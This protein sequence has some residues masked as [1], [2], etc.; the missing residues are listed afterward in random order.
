MADPT[1]DNFASDIVDSTLAQ[2]RD[3]RDI[4]GSNDLSGEIEVNPQAFL[5][6]NRLI[7]GPIAFETSF[8]S[9]P[10]IVFGDMPVTDGTNAP[11][12]PF[13]VPDNYAPFLVKAYVSSWR[14]TNG[15]FDGFN[16]GLYAL[17]TPPSGVTKHIVWWQAKGKASVYRDQKTDESWAEP[18]DFND[19]DFLT[20][21]ADEDT[22][23]S[24]EG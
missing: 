17:T 21:S 20:E 18:Y 15:V 1:D 9:R 4:D 24:D 23:V 19:A 11:N 2:I 10:N 22:Y 5:A 8:A 6:G 16:L 12:E 14:V 7:I 13:N 3:Q